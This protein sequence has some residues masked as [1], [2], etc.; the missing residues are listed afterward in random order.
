MTPRAALLAFCLVV[1]V[2]GQP[3]VCAESTSRAPR[4]RAAAPPRPPAAGRLPDEDR[5]LLHQLADAQRNLGEQ[6]R[7]LDER[8]QVV[9]G[10]LA[11][12][13]DD[14][15]ADQQEVKALRE[16]VKGLYVEISGLKEQIEEVKGDVAGVDANVSGFRTF[17]GFF[18]AAMLLLL[19]AIFGLTIRR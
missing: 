5:T 17:S 10:E 4:A 13:K 1:L 3:G 18:I 16:E 6:L 15:T 11:A 9:Q 2:A 19:I 7:Q 14:E 8:L 12:G